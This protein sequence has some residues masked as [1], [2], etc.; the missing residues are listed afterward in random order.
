MQHTVLVLIGCSWNACFNSIQIRCFLF[1]LKYVLSLTVTAFQLCFNTR[2]WVNPLFYNIVIT[3]TQEWEQKLFKCLNKKE[4]IW[5]TKNGETNWIV[6]TLKQ[7]T[8]QHL[9]C[10]CALMGSLETILYAPWQHSHLLSS[11]STLHHK[12]HTKTTFLDILF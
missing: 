2:I 9:S 12:T 4:C 5:S 6:Y 7:P 1:Q 8:Y 10:L 3:S 11:H